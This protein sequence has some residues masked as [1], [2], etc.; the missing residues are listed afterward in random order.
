M[1]A[2]MNQPWLGGNYQ[3]P[4]PGYQAD[5]SAR[6]VFFDRTSELAYTSQNTP[7]GGQGSGN[8]VPQ[9]HV[10][11]PA[12][13]N[14]QNMPVTQ[15]SNPSPAATPSPTP[16]PAPTTGGGG[17]PD[18]LQQL[19]AKVNGYDP[20]QSIN[21]AFDAQ[22]QEAVKNVGGQWE[23]GMGSRGLLPS[24]NTSQDLK[25]VLTGK[26]M[27]PI[28]AQRAAALAGAQ[29]QGLQNQFNLANML[30]DQERLK[31]QQQWQNTQFEYTKSQDA[32]TRAWQQAQF[33]WQKQQAALQGGQW[34]KE[35][36]WRNS[37]TN[38][39]NV[40]GGV[41]DAQGNPIAPGSQQPQRAPEPN[42]LDLIGGAGGGGGARTLAEVLAAQG[43]TGGGGSGSG[44]PTTSTGHAYGG[45]AGGDP[46]PS[47][48][49]QPTPG[50]NDG[51][52]RTGT[53]RPFEGAGTSTVNTTGHPSAGGA[54][55]G[56]TSAPGSTT[57]TTAGS[58]LFNQVRSAGTAAAGGLR[59][60]QNQS[61][62]APKQL[63]SPP[64]GTSGAPFVVGPK[65][66]APAPKR[67]V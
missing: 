40:H 21:S 59:T 64:W 13:G 55:A 44:A 15:W 42:Y 8:Q 49:G 47:T 30:S 12:L 10:A 63:A 31:Q 24:D 35:F 23:G 58:G 7:F 16:A 52:G 46:S 3:A 26:A 32:A 43:Y 2:N 56:N 5:P 60:S 66:P 36:D 22:T 38:T 48:F 45:A 37:Q 17:Q 50:W 67:I 11:N 28:A 51:A 34:Q 19:I 14:N 53:A 29:Q 4:M 27:A 62:A 33:E 39:S 65:A 41:T 9:P 54:V 18:Y 25:A 20:T 57:A 6:P 1:A 61:Y